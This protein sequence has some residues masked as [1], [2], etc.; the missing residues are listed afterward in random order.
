MPILIMS[1]LRHDFIHCR[2]RRDKCPQ[3]MD[4]VPDFMSLSEFNLRPDKQ[5]VSVFLSLTRDDG[6]IYA[7]DVA[8]H[9]VSTNN[10]P[11]LCVYVMSVFLCVYQVINV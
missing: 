8:E 4:E 10:N 6:Y 2:F 3:K 1:R 11:S 9:K 7:E 5:I